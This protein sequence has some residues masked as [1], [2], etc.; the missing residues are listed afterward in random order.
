MDAFK[1]LVEPRLI[2][3]SLITSG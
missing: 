2:N 3:F 1:G